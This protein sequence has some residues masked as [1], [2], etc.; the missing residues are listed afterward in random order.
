MHDRE[1]TRSH[2]L[3][4]RLRCE[5]MGKVEAWIEAEMRVIDSEAY[6]ASELP[7][8]SDKNEAVIQEVLDRQAAGARAA[9]GEF[10]D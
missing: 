2:S 4:Y 3:G 6:S 9:H 10:G 1:V 8:G 7:L 5:L